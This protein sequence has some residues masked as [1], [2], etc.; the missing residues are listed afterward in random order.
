[1]IVKDPSGANGH[2]CDGMRSD[3][4]DQ[5]EAHMAAILHE[6][7]PLPANPP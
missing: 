4:V 3:S 6:D 2:D 5:N 7:P 1:M